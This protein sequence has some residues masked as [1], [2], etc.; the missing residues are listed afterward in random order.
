MTIAATIDVQIP[1]NKYVRATGTTLLP[2]RNRQ[3]LRESR[4]I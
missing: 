4:T 1:P 2:F 3:L